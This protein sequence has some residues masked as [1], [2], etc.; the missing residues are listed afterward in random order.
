MVGSTW[1]GDVCGRTARTRHCAE[2]DCSPIRRTSTST[3]GVACDR[4]HILD[5]DSRV[6]NGRLTGIN[7]HAFRATLPS[8]AIAACGPR[9]AV[10]ELVPLPLERAFGR[11]LQR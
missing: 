7:W 11:R 8:N 1:S 3:A 2:A 10:L 9:A 6:R 4:R 5:T